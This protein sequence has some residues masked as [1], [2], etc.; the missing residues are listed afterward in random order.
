[1]SFSVDIVVHLDLR[2]CMCLHMS[3]KYCLYRWCLTAGR[4]RPDVL[5]GGARLCVDV[6]V[7]G[8]PPRAFP[9][10]TRERSNCKKKKNAPMLCHV[11][12]TYAW[13]SGKK[14]FTKI[15]NKRKRKKDLSCLIASIWIISV[16]Q[17]FRFKVSL[18]CNVCSY[19]QNFSSS[20]KKKKKKAHSSIE[21]HLD[22]ITPFKTPICDFYTSVRAQTRRKQEQKCNWQAFQGAGTQISLKF[23][24]AMRT[25]SPTPPCG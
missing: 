17:V 8:V 1:M 6:C 13:I 14:E 5:T 4:W 9:R 22:L 21:H 11:D 23:D 12:L 2:T 24:R 20:F 10:S 18:R 15:A 25:V 3:P 19:W 7:W 16:V